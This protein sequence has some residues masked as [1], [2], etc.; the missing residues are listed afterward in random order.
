MNK[1]ELKE[2]AT[3]AARV[4]FFAAIPVAAALLSGFWV[5]PDWHAQK[6][7]LAAAAAGGAAAGLRAVWGAVRSGQLPFPRSG[8]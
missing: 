7:L 6:A 2:F 1:S 3:A 5:A 4:F 8:V